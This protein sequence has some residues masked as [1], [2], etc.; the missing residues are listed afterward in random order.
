MERTLKKAINNWLNAE[1]G[2]DPYR[3][4]SALRRVFLR[5]PRYAPSADFV[6]GVLSSLGLASTGLLAVP[7]LTLRWKVAIV[8]CFVLVALAGSLLPG[9]VGALWAGLGPGKAIDL[10][11]GLVVG[12]SARFAEGVVVWG[13]L[14]GV[15]RTVSE[16]LTSPSMMAA[17]A[18][19]A[20]ISATA[21]R[22]LHGL[23][24]PDR[25]P[26]YV[27]SN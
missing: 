20:L 12:L 8:V 6:A 25:N 19:A 24:L 10:A 21:L 7:R 3:A 16:S 23:M 27:Q 11:A 13:A 2:D 14:S 5:L 26:R 9:M 1:L 4:E 15:A 22:L 17:I 18:A